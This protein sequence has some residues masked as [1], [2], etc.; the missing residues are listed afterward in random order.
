MPSPLN[1]RSSWSFLLRPLLLGSLFVMSLFGYRYHTIMIQRTRLLFTI[2]SP[3][4][5]Q[6]EWIKATLDGQP[7]SNGQ[8]ISLGFHT[9]AIEQSKLVPWRTN[10]FAWYGE[11]DLATIALQRATGQLHLHAPNGAIRF[12]ING[13][14]YNQVLSDASTKNITVPTDTYQIQAEYPHWIKS[15]SVA[16]LENEAASCYFDPHFGSLHVTGNY[17]QTAFRVLEAS[18]NVIESGVTPATVVNLPVGNYQLIATTH[19]HELKSELTIRENQTLDM[20][21]N[22][23]FGAVQLESVPAGAQVHNDQGDYLGTT[24]LIVPDLTPQTIQFQLQLPGYE[25]ANVGVNIYGD[26]TNVVRTRLT[27]L[28]YADSMNTMQQDIAKGDF[29][30]AGAGLQEMLRTEPDN[31]AALNLQRQVNSQLAIQQAKKLAG[32]GDYIGADKILAAAANQNPGNAE[33]SQLQAQY[34][35]EEPKQYARR[36]LERLQRPKRV[37]TDAT[38][39]QTGTDYFATGTLL[40]TKPAKG[41]AQAIA[42]AFQGGQPA[43]KLVAVKSPEPE[44]FLIEAVQEFSTYLATSAGKRQVFISVGQAKD[45]ETQIYYKALEYK[46]EALNKFSLGNALGTPV[47]VKYVLLTPGNVTMTDAYKARVAEGVQIVKDRIQR[48][49]GDVKE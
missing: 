1:H 14:E 39:W 17:D 36:Q 35:A 49:L 6:G 40:T 20:P 30:H 19:R 43:F 26:Q 10:F 38:A 32:T 28:A 15:Q 48:A 2:M 22:F 44:C 18:G 42:L 34:E 9:L 24:P 25:V 31:A 5:W 8:K 21:C 13:P 37:F 45:H 47:E 29:V 11:R 16:V 4:N 33:I 3:P 7:V 12:T 27:S 41:V 23:V 46:T